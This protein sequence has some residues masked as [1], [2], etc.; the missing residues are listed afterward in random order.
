M[1]GRESVPNSLRPPPGYMPALTVRQHARLAA[2][3]AKRDREHIGWNGHPLSPRAL[4]ML[5][6]PCPLGRCSEHGYNDLGCRCPGCREAHRAA[7]LAR[8]HR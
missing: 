5:G 6:Q 2:D 7:R 8:L 3:Q 4:A 1:A